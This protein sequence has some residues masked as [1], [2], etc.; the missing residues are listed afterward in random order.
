MAKGMNKKSYL[1]VGI[2]IAALAAVYLLGPID[3]I[4]DFLAGVGQIDD[5]IV[6]ILS[7]IAEMKLLADSN[8]ATATADEAEPQSETEFTNSGFGAYKEI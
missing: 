7:A 1:P 8:K 2:A 3:I 4:P 6:L 5:V